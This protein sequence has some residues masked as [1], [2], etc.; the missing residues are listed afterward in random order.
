MPNSLIGPDQDFALWAILMSAATLGVWAERTAWG[1]RISGAVTTLLATFIL[2]NLRIIP[3]G[4]PTY[5]AVWAY[6]VPFAI[7]LLLFQADLR[8]I[9][10][11]TG[12]TLLAFILGA[13]GT[14]LGTISAYLV[15]PLGA[16]GWQLATVFCATYIGGSVNFAATA[17][18]VGLRSGDLLSAGVAADNLV[19]MLYFLL[20]F[21]LP[22]IGGLNRF[23]RWG[24]RASFAP[25]PLGA[26]VSPASNALLPMCVALTVSALICAVGKGIA[27]F[28]G[29]P[30]VAILVIT[31]LIV[32]LATLFASVLSRLSVAETLGKLLMQI[33]F[34]A[35]GAS[36]NIQVVLQVGP[37]LFLMAALILTLH[38]L[39]LLGAGWLFRLNLVEI[40]VASN[41]NTGGPTTAA[42]M[43]TARR[44]DRLVTPA[45]LCGTLGYA[46]ATFI[47]VGLGNVLRSWGG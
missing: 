16:G 45:I 14:V 2:S 3:I 46:M 44:W 40:A 7:P 19:M 21:T 5:D 32:A 34:A 6:L 11:E 8:R 27:T 41:A 10:R 38:L 36:A 35:I 47:G 26:A 20:L 43:A 9:V 12:P 37:I 15:L 31:I 30:S 23:Y 17:E 25:V 29:I 33:F 4:A 42:A 39:F 22:S 13:I 28:I 1:A 24:E 18:A